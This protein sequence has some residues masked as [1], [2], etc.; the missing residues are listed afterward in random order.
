MSRAPILG[1]YGTARSSNAADAQLIN[2]FLELIEAKEAGKQPGYLQMTPGLDRLLTVGAGPIRGLHVMGGLLYVVS[3]ATAYQL[4]VG[5]IWTKIGGLGTASG[6]VSMI[7]NGRQLAIFDGLA[8]YL[9]T[10]T[11][12]SQ[13]AVPLA[14]GTIS[15]GGVA[16]AVGDQ[17]TL[18]QSGG[19]QEATAIIQATVVVAGAVTGFVVVQGGLFSAAPTGFTQASTTSNGSG[20]TL[21]TPTFGASVSLTQINLPFTQGPVS[22]TYQ[23]G[24]GL[25]NQSGTP[26]V[27]QSNSFDLST[28]NALNYTDA[29]A[30]PD[31]VIALATLNRE[32]RFFKEQHTEVWVDAGLAGFSFQ[33]L[34][35]VFIEHGCDAPFSVA[36]AG[37]S[38]VWLARN[39][40]GERICVQSVGYEPKRISTHAVEKEWASY[41]AVSDAI[42]YC[43]QQEGHTFY[44]IAFPSADATWSIELTDSA[45]AGEPL[46]HQRAAF[47]PLSGEFH[48]H[49]S[50]AYASWPAGE[51][52]YQP[53]GI[54]MNAGQE[55]ATAQE[56]F[57]LPYQ[58]SD[59]ILS[60]WVYLPDIASLPGGLWFS[61]Q[62]NDPGPG[63]GGLQIGIFNDQSSGAGKQI[64][65]NLY[66]TFGLVHILT[67]EYAFASWA[68]WVWIGISVDTPTQTIQV[69]IN[70]GDGAGEQALTPSLLNW[71]STNQIANTP[72]NPWHLLPSTGPS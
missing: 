56:L 4:T 50:N 20:F 22:A 59:F 67:A 17:I 60:V 58:F 33:R 61:D 2:L 44:V 25:V 63:N 27:W 19:V 51:S 34:E 3:G 24:F 68:D 40:Q 28:W 13:G 69:Y 35:G 62:S 43:Y 16:Y 72:G 70:A 30:T 14:G 7:D 15:D 52:S 21:T 12:V 32:V 29:D 11:A 31:N 37:Q 23:D 18:A 8:G 5:L 1:G 9:T 41:P 65:V 53:K 66:D 38:L 45:M 64:F 71:T 47:D 39:A 48:R 42:G 10:A 57:D 54:V 36:L 46:W 49:Y 55:I 6:S 26:N